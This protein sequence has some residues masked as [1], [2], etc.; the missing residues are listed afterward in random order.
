[1]SLDSILETLR[2]RRDPNEPNMAQPRDIRETSNNLTDLFMGEYELNVYNQPGHLRFNNIG[3]SY[4]FGVEPVINTEHV[5]ILK[6]DE[7]GVRWEFNLEPLGIGLEAGMTQ[8]ASKEAQFLEKYK[9]RHE[10][11]SEGLSKQ[12]TDK[13]LREIFPEENDEDDDL[14]PDF[15]WKDHRGF[16]Y[17]LEVA[18]TR[19]DTEDGLKRVYDTKSFKYKYALEV[20]AMK[21]KVV[22]YG[23]IVLSKNLILSSIKLPRS[24]MSEL[25]VRMRIGIAL[26]NLA[27]SQG[28]SLETEETDLMHKAYMDEIEAKLRSIKF[29]NPR[30][31]DLSVDESFVRSLLGDVDQ[32][33]VME[34]FLESVQ[35]SKLECKD[36]RDSLMDP[37]EIVKGYKDEFD[38]GE[39]R[40]NSKSVVQLPLLVVPTT[41]SDVNIPDQML[42]SYPSHVETKLWSIAMDNYRTER[43]RNIEED[44]LLLMQEALESDATTITQF[45]SARKAQR[46]KYHRVNISS[47]LNSIDKEIVAESGLWAKKHKKEIFYQQRRKFTQLPFS[48]TTN[49]SDIDEFLERVDFLDYYKYK[50]PSVQMSMKLLSYSNK[51]ISNS[52]KGIDTVKSWINTRLFASLDL[53]SDIA[54]ELCISNK[55]NCKQGS[56]IL[57]KLR[58]HEAYL[59]IFPTKSSEH[60]FFTLYFPNAEVLCEKPFKNLIFTKHGYMTPLVS[61]KQSKL[62]NWCNASSSL[63]SLA[64][65][66]SWFYEMDSDEPSGFKSNVEARKM[67]FFSLLVR[68]EDKAQT[69]ESIT[70]TRYMYM[71]SFKGLVTPRMSNPLKILSKFTTR[72][73]SRLNL[74]VIKQVTANFINMTLNPPI[75]LSTSE[76][77]T[78][79][80]AGEDSLPKDTWSNLLNCFTG[81]PIL[82]A[83]RVINLV[84][85]G[86][87]KNKNESPEGNSDFL[88]IEK[89]LEE[90]LKLD[91]TNI[92]YSMGECGSETEPKG[93]QYNKHCIMHGCS[94]MEKKLWQTLGPDWK[95]HLGNKI[96]ENLASAMTETISSLKASCTINHS[97]CPKRASLGDPIAS[98]RCKVIEAISSHLDDFGLNPFTKLES[99]ISYIESTSGGVIADLFKKQQHGGLREIYVLTIESRIVQLFIEVISRT[100]CSFFDEET[101]THPKNKLRKLNEHRRLSARLA[102][103]RNSLVV[104]LCSSND[105]TRW[106]QNFVM[107]AMIIPLIRLTPPIFHNAIMRIVNLWSNKLIK[108]PQS[109][110]LHL[111]NRTNFTSP[112]FRNLLNDFWSPSI[113]L[114]DFPAADSIRLKSGMMQGILHYTSSLLHLS[115]LHSGNFMIT[116]MLKSWYPEHSFLMTQICSSD[117]SATMLSVFSPSDSPTLDHGFIKVACHASLCLE[118]LSHSCKYFCMQESLKS[119]ISL[120]DYVEFNSEFMFSNTIAMPVVKFVA[121]SLNLTESESFIDRFY[122]Q[123]NL[124]SDLYGSGFTAEHT[125]LC[126]LSQGLLHYKTMGSSS[127]ALFDIWHETI[128]KWPDPKYGFF[129]LDL[130]LMPGVLGYSYSHWNVSVKT[131]I[132]QGSIK[133]LNREEWI[134]TPEGGITQSLIMKHGEVKRWKRLV[135][136]VRGDMDIKVEIEKDPSILFR[137]PT[138]NDE[139]KLKLSIIA[140]CPGV[141]RSMRRGNPFMQAIAMSVYAINTHSFSKSSVI[142]DFMG[143]RKVATKVCLL[144]E[145]ISKVESLPKH[146]QRDFSQSLLLSF[147][148]LQKYEE[149]STVI[150]RLRNARLVPCHRFRERKNELTIQP[151]SA[152]LPLSLIQ[153]V[154]TRWFGYPIRASHKIYK[155]CL[156][157]YKSSI[158]WLRDDIKTCL[159]ESPFETYQELYNFITSCREKVRVFRRNGPGLHSRRLTGQIYNLICKSQRPNRLLLEKGKV[160]YNIPSTDLIT[161]INLSLSI[162]DHRQRRLYTEQALRDQPRLYEDL[163]SI[164][165]MTRRDATLAYIQGVIKNDFTLE[166]VAIHMRDLGV[167]THVSYV[168]EQRRLETPSGVIWRGEGLCYLFLEGCQLQ[169]KMKDEYL[170]SLRI[171]DWKRLR[172]NMYS[173]N[174][175]IRE[176][177][178]KPIP[179][180]SKSPTCVAKYNGTHLITPIG[181]G[182]P[183]YKLDQRQQVKFDPS[184]LMIR[185]GLNEIN[186]TQ[187]VMSSLNPNIKLYDVCMLK[188][189]MNHNDIILSQVE[190]EE[191]RLWESW[192]KQKKCSPETLSSYIKAAIR[193]RG[194][195][196]N[197]WLRE[198]LQSRLHFKNFGEFTSKLYDVTVDYIDQTLAVEEDEEEVEMINM[199]REGKLDIEETQTFKLVKESG[200]RAL[201]DP[202]VAKGWLDI[203]S[204]EEEEEDDFNKIV[205]QGLGLDEPFPLWVSHVKNWME[206]CGE[207][208]TVVIG[209]TYGSIFS[210]H[211]LW[212]SFIMG[213]YQ[214]RQN[215]WM[216]VCD[217]IVPVNYELVA[218]DI[219][220]LLDIKPRPPTKMGMSERYKQ[221]QQLIESTFSIIRPEGEIESSVE[222]E[223]NLEF[224]E[225]EIEDVLNISIGREDSPT[226]MEEELEERETVTSEEEIYDPSEFF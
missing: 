65:F 29:I 53:I 77:E 85:L 154:K 81:S 212:D 36:L 143:R 211:P 90:E 89:T 161:K 160:K 209:P 197:S 181:V 68:L 82:S 164:S 60:M 103:K 140:T 224:Q 169:I 105:K 45:E 93:K 112:V 86:Y 16:Y 78:H 184:G 182:C 203:I 219:M 106:N 114:F 3:Y 189:R 15:L 186:I 153:V 191:D 113:G 109:V 126:Q 119:C 26:E 108:I 173:F 33:K 165:G 59:L 174:Q 220:K 38:K 54:I 75:K 178:L 1:M 73:K 192:V 172:S 142:H 204:A 25:I 123:Y 121:A 97:S 116:K 183:V 72:P 168:Q 51:L 155:K 21:D 83:S 222:E 193:D 138:N 61:V 41:Q 149:V 71:E 158:P 125:H 10:F 28:L 145:L 43:T 39:R 214:E 84:Y 12:S 74:W 135:S 31:S 122:T 148:N 57:K 120:L 100:I 150:S 156:D 8:T 32:K 134:T 94:L 144:G 208:S 152:A 139:L 98:M 47:G 201:K 110:C 198:S 92:N 66:W 101:L 202:S 35:R 157:S 76:R 210:V 190:G 133:E 226:V 49:T 111:L 58:Y 207:E 87:L 213:F 30:K 11:V 151:R 70:L 180:S 225:I 34:I 196:L 221:A 206:Y 99:F 137:S 27:K 88:L 215:F 146:D 24:L 50:N 22:S 117:D 188:Y 177:K 44:P 14:T 128:L 131:P 104:D 96:K 118:S 217:G 129:L 175:L 159:E 46:S 170:I 223:E 176:L 48:W 132:Y 102:H 127:N 62:E 91:T 216:E 205:L 162:P 6:H 4:N 56:A 195:S 42:E 124:I 40:F 2:A 52:K 141:A 171:D 200:E 67:L 147:P 19:N 130:D 107:S 115:F 136:N 199:I 167:G 80:V 55:Q 17:C 218:T 163:A 20:R 187:R 179:D 9:I 69:E 63:I 5:R 13:K 64:S 7:E 23:I 79:L 166:D 37:Y 18:T 194:S 95:N 185:I